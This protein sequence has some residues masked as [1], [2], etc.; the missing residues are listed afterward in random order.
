M[1]RM[2]VYI[3]RPSEIGLWP[4]REREKE[5]ETR[6]ALAD[7]GDKLV[8]DVPNTREHSHHT[9]GPNGTELTESEFRL[10]LSPVS[11]RI[12][13]NPLKPDH[14]R[15]QGALCSK[16]TFLLTFSEKKFFLYIS[17]NV[18]RWRRKCPPLKKEKWKKIMYREKWKTTRRE[19]DVRGWREVGC[20]CSH[21]QEVIGTVRP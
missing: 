4:P 3:K 20:T 6:L 10:D 15:S 16:L 2:N 14:W 7:I 18:Y 19:I 21:T 5:R 1:L 12:E 13:V 11:G 9:S 8:R 17:E